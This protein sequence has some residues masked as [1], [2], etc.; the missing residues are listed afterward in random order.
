MFAVIIC[1]G[2]AKIPKSFQKY[3]RDLGFFDD[4]V[5]IEEGYMKFIDGEVQM[6]TMGEI[7]EGFSSAQAP[8]N[9]LHLFYV[10]TDFGLGAHLP[11]INLIFAVK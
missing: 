3:A 10:K 2:H 9:F 7:F 5:L 11:K 8:E 4:Q 1:D 6:R